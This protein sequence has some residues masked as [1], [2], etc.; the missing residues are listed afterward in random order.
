MSD[1]LKVLHDKVN[2]KDNSSIWYPGCGIQKT[3]ITVKDDITGEV[4]F[5]GHNKVLIA[6]SSFTACKHFN[7]APPIKLP[8]YND[9]LSLD[10]SISTAAETPERVVLFAVGIDGCG[11]ESSQIFDVDYENWTKPVS[12]VPFRYVPVGKDITLAERDVYFGRKQT[13]DVIAYYFKAFEADPVM[14]QQ[15]IDGT[16]IDAN[17]YN[18][19]NTTDAETFVQLNLK[20]TNSDCR[21]FFKATD[22]LAAAKVNTI[23]LLTAWPKVIDGFTYYQ[24][25]QPLTK[26]NIQNEPL[27]DETKGLDIIYNIYY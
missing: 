2:P 13:T 14:N 25:I 20:I 10:Q 4:L 19:S 17:I 22:G 11:A 1:K 26:L 3:S 24:D 16:P 27:Y 7:I 15:Y 23:M 18:S 8:N 5:E 6:G 9:A 12:L 21:E